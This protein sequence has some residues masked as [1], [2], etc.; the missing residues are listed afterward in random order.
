MC[1]NSEQIAARA[2][3]GNAATQ[4]RPGSLSDR[5]VHATLNCWLTL[6]KPAGCA[7]V[8]LIESAGT[9][10]VAKAPG[11]VLNGPRKIEHARV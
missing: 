6:T 11:S 1:Q 2:T 5:V 3:A 7:S 4:Y 10:P 8:F 9:N